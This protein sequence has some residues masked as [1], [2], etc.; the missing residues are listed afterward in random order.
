MSTLYDYELGKV[1]ILK[2]LDGT[3]RFYG[4]MSDI[5]PRK[6]DLLA[7]VVNTDVTGKGGRHWFV[8]FVDC[9]P[10][11]KIVGYFNSVLNEQPMG[12]VQKWMNATEKALKTR[13]Y[14]V[15]QVYVN[16]VGHQQFGNQCGMY[17]LY[18]IA[19]LLM[20]ESLDYWLTEGER[21]YDEEATKLR[22]ILFTI[23]N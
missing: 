3:Q 19:T 12:D 14:E 18:F 2:V 9:R 20:G 4:C 15:E 22:N 23:E 6:C 10:V 17:S 13:N 8:V 5:K 16:K 7:C 11:K 1:D 21:I